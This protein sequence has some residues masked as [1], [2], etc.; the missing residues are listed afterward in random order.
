MKTSLFLLSALLLVPALANA[1][2]VD[3]MSGMSGGS[4][5]YDLNS[6]RATVAPANPAEPVLDHPPMAT[7]GG[8]G[9]MPMEG[10]PVES[11]PEQPAAI[12]P[13]PIEVAPVNNAPSDSAPAEN[14][15]MAPAPTAMPYGSS[16]GAAPPAKNSMD[17]KKFCTLKISFGSKC[18]GVDQKAADDIKTYLDG[19]KDDLSYI[20]APWGKEGEFD[21]CIDIPKH[22]N[23]AKIYTDL[24]KMLVKHGSPSGNAG[25]VTLT[26]AGFE[27]VSTDR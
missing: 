14:G 19:K 11:T 2:G 26:G 16:I 21:Y 18:C 1:Q 24:K 13:A 15:D 9:M 27:R 12:E 8:T 5:V 17:G 25:G 20:S 10:V 4:S 6:N 23:R 22:G 7:G 3:D